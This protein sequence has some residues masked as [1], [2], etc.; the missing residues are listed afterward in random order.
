MNAIIPL[1]IPSFISHREIQ[2]KIIVTYHH[3][4]KL[5][6][7]AIPSV[8]EDIGELAIWDIAGESLEMWLTVA[9]KVKLTFD[10]DLAI[11][12]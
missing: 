7:L 9:N 10:Y 1:K 12:S 4:L 6:R 8:G 3:T 2:S 11:P 5:K